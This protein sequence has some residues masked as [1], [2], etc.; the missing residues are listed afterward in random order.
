MLSARSDGSPRRDFAGATDDADDVA[1]VDVDLA[2]LRDVADHLETPGA[3]DEIEEDELAHAAPGHRA[4][5]EPTGRPGLATRLE[6]L[7]LGADG[8][9]LVPVGEA[10]RRRHGAPAYSSADVSSPGP[11]GWIDRTPPSARPTSTV[12]CWPCSSRE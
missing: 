1:E 9:D 12:T 11:T 3:I 4:T 8:R 6:R 2:R 5:G 7:R 10:L